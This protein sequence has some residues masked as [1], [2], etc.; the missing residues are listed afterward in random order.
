MG[1]RRLGAKRLDAMLKRGV[2][3]KDTS[4]R[5][6]SDWTGALKSHKM[7]NDGVFITTEIVVDLGYT[8]SDIVGAGSNDEP[9]GLSGGSQAYIMQWEDDIHGSFHMAEVYVIEVLNGSAAI[10]LASGTDIEA[11]DDS[12][13]GRADIIAGVTSNA[14]GSAS[15]HGSLADGEYVY[16]TE[17]A[18]SSGGSYTTGQLVIRLIGVKSSDVS[19]D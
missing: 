11:A 10:S 17:D 4:Y 15:G 16:I 6:G 9:I 13:N 14:V 19:A 18:H 2:T 12:I 1:N 8:G 5:A 7:F 3:G